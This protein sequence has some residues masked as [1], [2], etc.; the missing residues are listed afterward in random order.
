MTQRRYRRWLKIL[1]GGVMGTLVLAVL[2]FVFTV[3]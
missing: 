3:P 2:A 1:L